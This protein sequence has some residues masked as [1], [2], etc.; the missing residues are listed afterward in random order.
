M[1]T[2]T[3]LTLDADGTIDAVIDDSDAD[4]AFFDDCNDAPDGVSADYIQNDDSETSGVAWFSLSGVNADFASMDALNI[5]VDVEAVGFS[6]DSCTLTARI[7]DADNDTS[8]PLTDESGT[9]GSHTDSTR[10]QRNVKFSGLSGR[11]VQ[12]DAAYIRFTWTY[13]K[14][15]GPDNANLR[16]YGCDLDGNY[17]SPTSEARF[18][19]GAMGPSFRNGYARFAGESIH[20]ELW[21]GLVFALVPELGPTGDTLHE[22]IGNK[23]GTL[24]NMEPATD[25]I[26]DEQGWALEANATN[27]HVNVPAPKMNFPGTFTF[28]QWFKPNA[29]EFF[30]SFSWGRTDADHLTIRSGTAAQDLKF[31]FD[32]NFAGNVEVEVANLVT[33]GQ[34][35]MVSVTRDAGDTLHLWHNGVQQAG[36]A[37]RSG[38]FEPS[39]NATNTDL[40]IAGDGSG[41]GGQAGKYGPVLWYNRKLTPNEMRLFY[42]DPLAPF[43]RRPPTPAK[44][45]AA[46]AG[47]MLFRHPGM[48][49]NMQ[50]LVGEMK[51]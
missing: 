26:V 19:S 10:I 20:P 9:L 24:M 7:F 8:N 29:W 41:G 48:T 27:E 16:I 46:T 21:K 22:I 37:S 43:R 5:D 15:G 35:Q 38:T 49:G 31:T 30:F 23:N 36:S 28:L 18:I 39:E 12:W 44:A 4:S 6:N 50:D 14:S 34:W 11:K 45:P 3:Q 1:A 40:Q 17:H 25:W 42:S 2:L 33:N 13:T 32:V 47:G 51:A